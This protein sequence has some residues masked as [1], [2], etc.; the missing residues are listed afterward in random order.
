V[1]IRVNRIL[2]IFSLAFW[3]ITPLI[4]WRVSWRN[5]WPPLKAK[6]VVIPSLCHHENECQLSVNDCWWCILGNLGGDRLYRVINRV[7]APW[8]GKRESE[9]LPAPCWKWAS[10]ECQRLLPFHH[11]SSQCDVAIM[12]YIPRIDCFYSLKG[13]R[14]LSN[15]SVYEIS[16][17][18]PGGCG[19]NILY[20][21][22]YKGCLIL[23]Y[24]CWRSSDTKNT[25]DARPIIVDA[26]LMV[27]WH[28]FPGYG[29]ERES[30]HFTH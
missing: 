20:I 6:Q 2:K 26:P 28:L 18:C 11:D 13:G 17:Y 21:S 27:H 1:K 4:G 29:R 23:L 9:T 25:E 14:I 8:I 10:T 12:V 19:G 16:C 22:A 24:G 5:F 7:L 15:S 30:L 3:V